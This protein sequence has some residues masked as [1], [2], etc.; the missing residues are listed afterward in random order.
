[1]GN[2]NIADEESVN[3][4]KRIEA[5]AHLLL[6]VHNNA[7]NGPEHK[8]AILDAEVSLFAALGDKQAAEAMEEEEV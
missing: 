1:M 5:A 7:D 4:W 8:A 6:T 2:L 3:R